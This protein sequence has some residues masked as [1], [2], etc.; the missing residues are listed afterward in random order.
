[1]ANIL[2]MRWI[3]LL[4]RRVLVGWSAIRKVAQYGVPVGFAA[5]VKLPGERMSV[6]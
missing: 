6:I 5:E 4:P 3:V 2:L 1:V